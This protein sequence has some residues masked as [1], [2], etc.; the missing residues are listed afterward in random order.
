MSR[1]TKVKSLPAPDVKGSLKKL[2]GAGVTSILGVNGQ[3]TAQRLDITRDAQINSGANANTSYG[4]YTRLTTAANTKS[5]IWAN[6]NALD[7]DAVTAI[8]LFLWNLDISNHTAGNMNVWGITSENSG[9][10]EGVGNVQAAVA[11][12]VT[13]QYHTFNTRGWQ[14]G[15][16]G[17]SSAVV[18]YRGD[19]ALGAL[20][21]PNYSGT[22]G[23]ISAYLSLTLNLANFKQW[24]LDEGNA[25]LLLHSPASI[26]AAASREYTPAKPPYFEYDAPIIPSK[27]QWVNM[28]ASGAESGRYYPSPNA[29]AGDFFLPITAAGLTMPIMQN[30][31]KGFALS[32][33][34]G[35]D[36]IYWYEGEG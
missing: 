6:F 35:T 23:S 13:W 3:N 8:R 25:G 9:W 24:L 26:F 5:L 19:L 11:G 7:L 18:D 29:D 36:I 12:D 34:V 2:V 20:A 4:K 27:T 32:A 17:L 30:G 1:V 28:I 10:A 33:P 22:Q 15:G 16:Q 31:V 21:T 14:S